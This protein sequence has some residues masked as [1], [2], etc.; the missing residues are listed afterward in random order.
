M[1]LT[2]EWLNQLPLPQ[3]QAAHPVSGGDINEA[4]QLDTAEGHTFF[5]FSRVNLSAFTPTG[6]RTEGTEPLPMHQRSSP[7][8]RLSVPTSLEF[9]ETVTGASTNWANSCLGPPRTAKQFGFA[10]SNLVSKLPK[11][12]TW[13]DDWTT[14]YLEQR[15]DP[16][17]RVLRRIIWNASAKPHTTMYGRPL[18]R[19]PSRQIQPSL[20]TAISG[21]VT[22]CSRRRCANVD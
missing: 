19:E 20:C 4:F 9:L 2:S 1:Q 3:I 21:L 10:D 14:F 11:N 7:L 12:N 13:Q 15:L 8:V 18:S 17:V 6:C 22:I 5:W 16:L